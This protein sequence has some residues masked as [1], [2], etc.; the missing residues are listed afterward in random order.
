MAGVRIN[1]IPKFL[2]EEKD[3]NTHSIIANGPLNPNEPL[4]IPL[5]LKGVKSYFPS[6][7]TMSSEYED[8]SITHIV[9]IWAVNRYIQRYW[10]T[11]RP[12]ESTHLW[13]VPWILVWRA[14]HYSIIKKIR[15]LDNRK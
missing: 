4:A 3:Y 14:S 2:A 11:T 8:E 9:M 5:V 15:Q 12:L 1:E 7:N 6:R 10:L 13:S